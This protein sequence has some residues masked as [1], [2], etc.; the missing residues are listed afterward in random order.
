MHMLTYPGHYDRRL[1]WFLKGVPLVLLA[2]L[3]ALTLIIRLST[4]AAGI[5][6][7]AGSSSYQVVPGDTLGS[8]AERT[9]TTWQSL[10]ASNHLM[11]ANLI[12]P[13]QTLCIA[14]Q[15]SSDTGSG[16]LL[17]PGS[18]GDFYPQG[19][20]TW[21]ADERYFQIHHIFVPWTTNADAW[22]WTARAH[23]FN[24][25]VS[26]TPQVGDIID[27]QPNVQLASGL[28]HVG[29]VEQILPNGHVLASNLNWGANPGQIAYVEFA[30]GPG[31]TF[32]RQ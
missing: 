6:C 4:H 2:L 21:W 11:N 1:S 16:P 29:V 25:I 3:L 32:I 7:P 5:T 13:G 26:S 31:V 18:T 30:P 22:Q 19:Q 8:I 14:G 10:A 23:D 20:C 24:W 28:G 15:Q 9:R 12:F 17:G 27:L